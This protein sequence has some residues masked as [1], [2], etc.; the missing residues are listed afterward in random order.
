MESTR[1]SGLIAAPFTPFHADYSLNLDVVPK[2]AEHLVKNKVSGAFV[3]G[4][5]GESASLTRDERIQLTAAWRKVAG[6]GLK[7]IV[8]V[9]HNCLRDSQELARHAES[10]GA[11]CIAAVMPSFFRPKTLAA[12]VNFCRLIAA[13]APKTP[14]YYYHIPDMTGVDFSMA[15]FL[16]EAAKSIPTFKGIKFTHSNLMDYS[17]ALAAAGDRYDVLFGRDENLLA[18]LAFGAKGAVGSTYNYSAGLYHKLMKLHASD[19]HDEASQQQVYIQR[20]ILPLIR[21]GGLAAGKAVMA[22][23]GVDCGPVRPPLEP[24]EPKNLAALKQELDA[25]DFFAAIKK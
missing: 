3:G 15:E 24:L 18:G 17:L 7:L 21:Y 4:T 13:A 9:G 12:T 11:D 8:H 1:L 25:L 6:P 16:P 10:V 22:L 23:A 2:I 5:T 14:F 20:T 19:K